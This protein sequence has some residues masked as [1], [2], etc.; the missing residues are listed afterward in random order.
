MCLRHKPCLLR[1]SA[2]TLVS[3]P[4][5]DRAA[6]GESCQALSDAHV[7][8]APPAW[9]CWERSPPPQLG[10]QTWQYS[11]GGTRLRVR[12]CRCSLSHPTGH[13]GRY[14]AA[15]VCIPR[16]FRRWEAGAGVYC[17]GRRERLLR[18]AA[19]GMLTEQ[20]WIQ[21]HPAVSGHCL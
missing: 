13:T 7:P 1:I 12:P 18:S 15:N 6:P 20:H 4:D 3:S 8:A 14:M 21:S 17:P 2:Q 5:A 9:G 16:Q 10:T 11:P 19:G